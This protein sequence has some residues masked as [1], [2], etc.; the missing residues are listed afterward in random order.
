[1]KKIDPVHGSDEE[2]KFHAAVIRKWIENK[3]AI[4]LSPANLWCNHVWI[5][6]VLFWS[7]LL[8][9]DIINFG[10]GTK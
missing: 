1:M 4:I 7:P 2:G 10:K 8:K 3:T 5:N 6:C 9:E